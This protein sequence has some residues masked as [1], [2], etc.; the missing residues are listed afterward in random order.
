METVLTKQ[1][2][3]VYLA[4]F[5]DLDIDGDGYLDQDEVRIMVEKQLRRPPDE[6]EVSFFSC[7][8]LGQSADDVVLCAGP[9]GVA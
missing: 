9:N 7:L 1:E 4:D 3:T 5:R 6:A 2:Y 8:F